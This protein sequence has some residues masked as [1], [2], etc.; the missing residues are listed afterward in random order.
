MAW[1]GATRRGGGRLRGVNYRGGSLR[2]AA[3]WPAL[4]A[5]A[6][7]ALIAAQGAA[8]AGVQRPAARSAAS[9]QQSG[10][11]P[12]DVHAI[13]GNASATVSWRGPA[14][15]GGAPVT[16]WTVTASTGQSVTSQQPDNWAIVTGL[17]NGTAVSFTVTATSSA[18]TSPASAPSGSVTPQPVPPPGNVLLGKPQTVSYDHYSL[19]IG[20]KRVFI[21][22]GE[23]DP[24][25]TP[26]PSLWLDRLEAMKAAGF[27]AVTPYF[28][29]DYV[30]P[31]PG[32]YDFTGVRDV[33]TF[34]NDAQKAG[35]YVIAR[36]GPY[37][38]AET[39]GGG[40]PGWLDTQ[41]GAARYNAPDY[42]AAAD[43]YLS[44]IDPIIAAHQITRGGDVILYQ[45]ENENQNHSAAS[46]AGMQALEAKVAADG[47]KVPTTA[48]NYGSAVSNWASGP[49]AT[50]LYGDDVYPLGFNCFNTTAFGNPPD[51]SN[52]HNL[53]GP[54]KP[55]FSPE[56]QGGS[57]DPW[58]G[59]GYAD[60]ATMTGSS[61]EN[62]YYK[63]NL[64][65]GLTMQS[66]YM[67][68]G[69]TNWGWLPAPFMYTSYDYGAAISETGQLPGKY[70][71]DKLIIEETQAIPPLEATDRV[72]PPTPANPAVT[73]QE[74]TNSST[75]TE[76][77]YLRQADARSTA[78]VTT[79]VAISTP[80]GSYP[81]V[82]QQPGTGITLAGRDAKFLV[83]DWKFGGPSGD[84]QNLV[85]STSEVATQASNSSTDALL[86]YGDDGT[87]GETVLRYSAQPTVD[88]LSGN[89]SSTWDASRGDLRLDYTHSGV[90]E[91]RVT[92]GS[93]S[94]LLLI[95]THATAGQ[96]WK[97]DAAGDAGGPLLVNGGSAVRTPRTA[98]VRGSTLALTG[99]T[100]ASGP[101]QVWAPA[102]VT[103]LTW[104]GQDIATTTGKD[105]SLDATLPGPP[106]V[107]LPA[108]G[109]WRFQQES[110]ETQ[111]S[112][113]DSQWQVADHMSTTNPA[114]PVTLPVLYADDYGFHHGFVWYRGHFTGSGTETGI[115][116]TGNGG[117]YGAFSVWLNGTF[118]GSNTA[119]GQQQETFAFPPSLP[120]H[121][122]GNVVSVLVEN[123]G[124]NED[125]GS[126]DA[127]KEPRGLLGAT[128]GT[129][130]GSPP[131]VTWRLQGNQGGTTLQDPVRG[132]MNPA[133]LYGTNHGWNLP[134]YPDQSWRPVSLPDTWAP[135][136][137]APGVGWYRTSFSLNLPRGAWSPIGLKIQPPGGGAP[138]SGQPK[139]Q[140]FIYLNGWLVG[141]YV[142]YLGP[143]SE[144]YLPQGILN[145][146][147]SNTLAIAVWG[148]GNAGGGLG[149]VSLAPYEVSGGG[150]PVEQVQ[151]PGYSPSVY[152]PPTS[153]GRPSLSM[154]SSSPLAEP[155]KAVTVTSTLYNGG[156]Q[157]LP[158]AEIAA[159]APAGWTV[160]PASA[161]VG[162]VQPGRTAKATFTV[163]P[164][165][166]LSGGNAVISGVASWGS[167]AARESTGDTVSLTVPYSSLPASFDDPGITS[168]ANP[169]PS[170]GFLG[171]DGKGTAYSAEGLAAA[172]LTPGA[173]V[174]EN[175][176]QLSWP[177]AQPA[178]NDNTM[179]L[180]QVIGLS[181]SGQSLTF[182]TA[183][184][185]SALSGTGTVYYTD[186]SMSSFGLNVGNFWY[187]SGQNGNPSNTQ[188]AAV[189]Y[190]NYPSG[191]SGH[192][193]YVF[194]VSV[195]LQSG[196]TVEAVQLPSLSGVEGYHAALHIFAM[197]IGQGPAAA[198]RPQQSLN[199]PAQER[200]PS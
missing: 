29:W 85:Y 42:L 66:N 8:Q 16:S 39:D 73:A 21:Y 53:G 143:Q 92:E 78:T 35:L 171:F 179:A 191:S 71:E 45:V 154:T 75:G 41:A 110:P 34:L 118:L 50:D 86:L 123:M 80:D 146:G 96:F 88:V 164:G 63:Q 48:N 10:G 72:T 69:G 12:A 178:Q 177:D 26:S 189:N 109:N 93:R 190:A 107:S 132:V 101:V 83:A 175:G 161:P 94:L 138:G 156:S 9:T 60:C 128:L 103:H 113:N 137:V 24:W 153:T 37:I 114:K 33:N 31:A 170:A 51:I 104:N 81:S 184:N 115:T 185:N 62:V 130:S 52:T 127:Q 151:A 4:T 36:P 99:D 11:P 162:T 195:P 106:Q 23:F 182:L 147:G 22:A 82:P 20:G 194:A 97:M 65:A 17:A 136:G 100:T 44:A 150:I 176:A 49:G 169:N 108:L 116:L 155:G 122:A 87:P 160:Q 165:S 28:D 76:F 54:D 174:T 121:G 198:A 141:R 40:F 188:V 168:D 7:I 152:G 64:S 192:T 172:G 120:R 30:S 102:G 43:Q 133:G 5:A 68:V 56:Y 159:S 74:E 196:K 163:T 89:V 55:L 77:L 134:G 149:T 18:G 1:S 157:A 181:G 14:Q 131:A 3:R 46:I 135:R 38:N 70:A 59:A 95:G 125:G 15:V 142:S 187:P 173:T 158:G 144:F 58:G 197:A 25:R 6:A 199:V 183:T 180:G 139:F 186:G 124:H 148:V 84:A 57:F 79:N 140:A 13:P 105:G 67:T 27:N 19:I 47:I 98:S 145:T 167:G 61:F 2:R 119:G 90:A 126:N 129:S 32:V 166:S 91:V 112:Y 111:L 193:V 117:Q 200:S